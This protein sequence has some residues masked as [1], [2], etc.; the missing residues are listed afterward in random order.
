MQALKHTSTSHVGRHRMQVINGHSEEHS[1][2]E[3]K[4]SSPYWTVWFRGTEREL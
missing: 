4:D 2:P 1:Q 3:L